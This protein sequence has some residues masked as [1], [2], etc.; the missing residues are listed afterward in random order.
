M[1]VLLDLEP[2]G[3]RRLLK[4]GLRGGLPQSGLEDFLQ[5]E[6]SWT[7]D[8]PEAKA[9]LQALAE[10]GWFVRQQ[11]VWKTHLAR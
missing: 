5:G 10:K 8:D 9:L 3:L 1:P 2:A 7:M 4:F 6:W 11:D